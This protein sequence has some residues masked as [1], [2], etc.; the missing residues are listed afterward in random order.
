M[1]CEYGCEQEAKYIVAR[2]NCCSS[3]YNSCP[4]I[5]RKNS[6]GLKKAHKEGRM[7]YVENAFGGN[8]GWAS[9][10]L[11]EDKNTFTYDGK[12]NHKALL[13][14]ERGYKCESCLNTEW[15]GKPIPLELEHCDG[16][17]RNNTKENLK[18]LCCNCHAMTTTWRGR[19]AKREKNK[20]V[21]DEDLIKSLSQSLNIREALLK[22]G[23][24]GKGG[25]YIRCKKLL[26]SG[27][28]LLHKEIIVNKK[29]SQHGKIWICHLDN[30]EN[31]KIPLS[32]LPYYKNL[33]WITGRVMKFQ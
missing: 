31:K 9:G 14:V 12:G 29:N 8:P 6:L 19:N 25:N 3:H 13:L 17:N 4:N 15:L 10:I 26:D 32:E 18:L 27:V 1:L 7:P 23:L 20:K 16:D 33:G 24:V 28:S 2:K 5:R 21:S 22:V 11:K 30:K